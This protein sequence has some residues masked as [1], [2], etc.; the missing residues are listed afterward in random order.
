MAAMLQSGLDV[1]GII[2]HELP[3]DRFEEAFDI[4]GGGECGKVILDWA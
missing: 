2:T 4:V 1:R 3:A